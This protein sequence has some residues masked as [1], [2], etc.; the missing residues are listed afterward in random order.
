MQLPSFPSGVQVPLDGPYAG[1]MEDP[2]SKVGATELPAPAQAAAAARAAW[3]ETIRAIEQVEDTDEAWRLAGALIDTVQ[4]LA[5]DLL[6]D[7][8]NLRARLAVRIRNERMLSL[9]GLANHLGVSK[10]RAQQWAESQRPPGE[11]QT[12]REAGVPISPG[13]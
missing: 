2:A 7:S 8:G 10:S 12:G 3:A 6:A 11:K 9:Q 13:G 1:P 5:A 4:E